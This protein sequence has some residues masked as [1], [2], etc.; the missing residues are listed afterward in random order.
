MDVLNNFC[1]DIKLW[2]KDSILQDRPNVSPCFEDTVLVWIPYGFLWIVSLPFTAYLF[3][4]E[5]DPPLPFHKLQIMKKMM[6]LA[7]IML[8]ISEILLK[9]ETGYRCNDDVNVP[10]AAYVA[11]VIKAASFLLILIVEEGMRFVGVK[12]C[13]ITFTFWLLIAVSEVIPVYSLIIADKWCPASTLTC[14]KLSVIWVQLVLRC[15]ADQYD[16]VEFDAQQEECPLEN[17]S[18]INRLTYTWVFPLVVKA[19]RKPLTSSGLWR[20]TKRL[21]SQY[22]V[23]KFLNNW[24]RAHNLYRKT[25]ENQERRLSMESEYD[26]P[27]EK[28]PILSTTRNKSIQRDALYRFD[29]M[30]PKCGHGPSI[31]SVMWRTHRG[32]WAEATTYKII[33]D[34]FDLLQPFILNFIIQ[35]IENRDT[36]NSKHYPKWIGYACSVALFAASM[37][38]T[39]FWNFAR[40][41]QKFIGQSMKAELIGAVYRKTFSLSNSAK[42]SSTVGEIVNLMAVDCQ[43]IQDSITLSHHVISI[44]F[45]T[46]IAMLQLWYLIGFATFSGIGVIIVMI[47][48]NGIL[49]RRQQW[50]QGLV[51][52][53]KSNRIK[54]LNEIINGI[55][56]LKMYTWE[57][58]FQKKVSALRNKEVYVL[59]KVAVVIAVAL[60]LSFFSPFMVSYA[61][62]VVYTL[63]KSIHYLDARTAFVVL[64]LVSTIR[65]PVSLTSEL[66][67]GFVQGYVSLKRIQEFLWKEDMDTRNIEHS[68]TS[69]YAVSI[70]NGLFTW[71][72]GLMNQT[73]RR[74]NLNVS[75]G[76]LIAVVGQVGSGKTSLLSA[77]LG[78]ME[79]IHGHVTLKGKIAYVPQEAWIQNLTVR[80][81]IVF[82]NTFDEIRYNKV[83]T[84]CALVSDLDMFPGGDQTEIGEKGINLSGGQKQRV[85]LARAVYSDA[86]IYLLDDPLSA[87]DSHVGKHLFNNVIGQQGLLKRRTRILV[88]HGIHWL[89]MVDRIVVI[90]DGQISEMGTYRELISRDGPFAQLLHTLAQEDSPTDDESD[91]NHI[92]VDKDNTDKVEERINRK[93]TLS[94]EKE[95]E[96]GMSFSKDHGDYYDG[97]LYESS[98]KHQLIQEETSKKGHVQFDVFKSYLKAMGYCWT[99]IAV[100]FM[101][102]FQTMSVYSNYWLTYWTED[103]L[104]KNTSQGHTKAYENKFVYYLVGYTLIGVLQGVAMLL[105]GIVISIRMAIASGIMHK[106]MLYSILRSPM[107][108]FDTTP[109]GRIMNRFSSDIDIMDVRIPYVIRWLNTQIFQLAAI[110]IVVSINTPIIMVVIVPVTFIYYLLLRFYL[111][112]VRQVTRLESVT[113]SP[114]FNHFSE[115]ITGAGVIRAYKCTD[116]FITELDRRVDQNVKFMFASICSA[117]WN[118]IC[119]ESLGNLLILTTAVFAF[120]SDGLNGAQVG[121]SITYAL[122]V[123]LSLLRGAQLLGE[124][125]MR[126]ISIERVKEYTELQPESAWTIETS[127]PHADWPQNGSVEF[128]DYTT[129]YRDG[130]DLTL[131][132]ISCQIRAGEKIGI[133]GRTGAGKSSLALSL[134]RL[135]ESAGGSIVIDGHD[136]ADIGLH[137]L[138]EKLTIL[139][140][141]PT[142]FSGSLRENIDPFGKFDDA[143]LWKALECAH[144]KRTVLNMPSQLGY[145]CGESGSNLSVGQKQLVCLAR[146]LL[147]KTKI[148]VLDEAT[149]AVDLE[150]DELIQTTIHN[151]FSDCTILTIAHRLHTVLDYDRVMV[152]AEGRIVELETPGKLLKNKNSVFFKMAKDSGLVS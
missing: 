127:K 102:I 84:G 96:F 82:S 49:G 44:P 27:N 145:E 78:E 9:K 108:F 25:K 122:Q 77:M 5:R 55:K 97:S 74:I 121:L 140:Q 106:S 69:K 65:H 126:V 120:T 93:R 1:G 28:T 85:S 32:Q 54:I 23:G 79:K 149:A 8:V 125:E 7:L 71:N 37:M 53:Y 66:I 136:I 48:L 91:E 112:T 131:K 50:L 133:V 42:K 150:T 117:K 68:E 148:L 90:A 3:R 83:I 20:Q 101:T 94:S 24:N 39:F 98:D 113:R 19:Y 62:Y 11:V 30:K 60:F 75:E 142:L 109:V 143:S 130:L 76:E 38:K 36:T 141:D 88:T 73:L 115:T 110:L 144:L 12:S 63:T 139:P 47:I 6:T 152:L 124:L 138:R 46:S 2:D 89:S 4:K 70:E 45:V 80:D 107:A 61:F 58:P 81:N 134:F 132:G 104:L 29:N 100:I 95:K 56:V 10:T 13:I 99:F 135:I 92:T 103:A 147:H 22:V 35:M 51:L 64:A 52:G 26:E 40:F 33:G 151:E 118:A 105:F 119:L 123:T 17:A 34:A 18:F 146:T 137:D 86:D 57:R 87:V 15:F 111:P 31:F 114:I 129:R 16:K 116:K 43:R 72:K 128:R 59:R 14:V 21:Q 41:S 67:N